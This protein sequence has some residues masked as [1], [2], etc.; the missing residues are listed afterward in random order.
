MIILG[1]VGDRTFDKKLKARHPI[2]PL[3][4]K[5]SLD[6]FSSPF[7]GTS[8]HYLQLVP[9]YLAPQSLFFTIPK[10]PISQ[11]KTKAERGKRGC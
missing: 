9:S 3:H 10:K 7:L 2:I 6:S 5:S 1:F 11:T 4:Q 8:L